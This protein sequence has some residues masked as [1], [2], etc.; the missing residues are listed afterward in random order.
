MTRPT[1]KNEFGELQ[2]VIVC[3]P[4]HMSITEVINE[5]QKHFLEENIDETLATKQH[6]NF[7]QAM[8]ANGVDVYSLPPNEQYPEQVFT[9]DIGF[10][11]GEAVFVSKMGSNIRSGE[12]NILKSWLDKQ[13]FSY[14]SFSDYSVEGGDIIIDR[15]IVYI[16]ISGRTSKRVLKHISQSLTEYTVKPIPIDKSYLHLDCVFNVISPTEALVF[17]PALREEEWNFL[18]KR[19]E[20]IEVSKEEQFTMGTNVLSIGN[21]I[22][23]SLPCNKQVNEQLRNRGY[24]VV[25]VDISEIIK[26]GG[27]FRCCTLPLLRS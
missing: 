15:D 1:C 20:L 13:H 25:E 7:V 10:T 2:K 23:F 22:I 16:G 11:L 21:K 19:Y 5:T 4:T 26:S 9:R 27:S 14:S 12:E 8:T 3:P 18:S 17:S 6:R 24:D